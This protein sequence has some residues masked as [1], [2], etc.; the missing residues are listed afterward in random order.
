MAWQI[1]LS[2]YPGIIGFLADIHNF[3]ATLNI[4][5]VFSLL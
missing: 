5:H 3:S 4:L 2:L 1:W